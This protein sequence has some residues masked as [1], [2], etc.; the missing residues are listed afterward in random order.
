MPNCPDDVIICD[1][2]MEAECSLKVK[3]RSKTKE[4]NSSRGRKEGMLMKDAGDRV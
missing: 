2:S 3:I 4:F 1:L